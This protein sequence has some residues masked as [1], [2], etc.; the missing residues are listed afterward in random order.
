MLAGFS[1]KGLRKL[2][3]GSAGCQGRPLANVPDILW[4]LKAI[5]VDKGLYSAG[6]LR[7]SGHPRTVSKDPDKPARVP[8]PDN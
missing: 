1:A 3:L 7:W 8:I 4:A 6:Q 5:P 2:K